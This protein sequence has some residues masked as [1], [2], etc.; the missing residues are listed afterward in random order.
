MAAHL[1]RTLPR[2]TLLGCA[3]LLVGTVGD[4]LYHSL[5]IAWAHDLEPLVGTDAVRAHVLTLLGMLLLV[6]AVIAGGV[7]TT[8]WH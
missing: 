2:L 4:V 1:T 5:P 8:F 6:S 3:V 7:R